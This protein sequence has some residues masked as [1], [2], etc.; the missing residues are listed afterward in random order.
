[1]KITKSIECID[2]AKWDTGD[3]EDKGDDSGESGLSLAAFL[4][5]GSATHHKSHELTAPSHHLRAKNHK[6]Q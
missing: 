6:R 1:M 2:K 3:D 5:T 4:Q